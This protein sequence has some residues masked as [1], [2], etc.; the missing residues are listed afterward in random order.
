MEPYRGISPHPRI[1]AQRSLALWRLLDGTAGGL[2][3]TPDAWL[4]RLPAPDEWIGRL[5]ELRLAREFPLEDLRRRLV[6]GGYK[7]EDPVTDPGEFSV[8][9][10]VLDVFSPNLPHP[11]RVEYFGDFVD[12][13]RTFDPDTQRSVDSLEAAEVVPMTPFPS[14]AD[15]LASLA[16]EIPRRFPGDAFAAN[17]GDLLALLE[18]GAAPPGIEFLAP[19]AAPQTGALWDYLS[20]PFQVID[21]TGGFAGRLDD[22]AA[23]H[24]QAFEE[25]Q[26]AGRI[27][28]PPEA[29]FHSRRGG[30]GPRGIGPAGFRRFPLGRPRPGPA[31]LHGHLVVPRETSPA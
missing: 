3:V 27:G 28:L 16:A 17:R 19:L 2:V 12:S 22:L 21:L 8:R 15:L 25:S 18:A 20:R 31:A 4:G 30:G 1:L 14:G 24:R 10:G 23:V 7:R 9:G 11:L 13:I 5:V 6:E 29:H 26:G